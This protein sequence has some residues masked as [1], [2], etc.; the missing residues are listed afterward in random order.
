M[1]P[2]LR[3]PVESGGDLDEGGTGRGFRRKGRFRARDCPF[4]V[5]GGGSRKEERTTMKEVP[6]ILGEV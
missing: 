1:G 5:K 3:E 6:L 4:D 2:N